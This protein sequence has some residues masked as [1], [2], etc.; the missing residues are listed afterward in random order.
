MLFTPHTRLRYAT[1]GQATL[2]ALLTA[3][4]L[5]LFTA[6]CDGP[7]GPE[8]PR[9][10]QGEQ[11]EQGPQGPQGPA[12]EDGNAN[13]TLYVFDGHDFTASIS[14][15]RCISTV[16][17]DD[18]HDSAWLVYFATNTTHRYAIPGNIGANYYTFDS[19]ADSALPC[20]DVAEFWLRRSDGPGNNLQS[21]HILQVEGT[22]TVDCTGGCLRAEGAP[23]IPED[24]NVTD[25]DAVMDYYGLT[26]NDIVRM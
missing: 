25:Y 5:L 14:T 10:A 19:Y 23:L 1:P 8:G 4:T 17:A 6:A 13:V 3:F 22:T 24:L 9:G 12:G 15:T 7:V 21:I 2:K 20:P 11:G 16:S 18:F 26:E